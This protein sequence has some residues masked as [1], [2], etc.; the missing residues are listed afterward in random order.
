MPYSE[1]L[2]DI[3]VRYGSTGIIHMSAQW[4]RC[5]QD[6]AD[7]HPQY[8]D[9]TWDFNFD[10]SK[11]KDGSYYYFTRCHLNDFAR[12][13]GFLEVSELSLSGYEG[14]APSPKMRS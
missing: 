3:T 14:D 12:K 7:A 8:R 5:L 4:K 10:N 6:W 11:H 2:L 9:K 13:Y 1:H